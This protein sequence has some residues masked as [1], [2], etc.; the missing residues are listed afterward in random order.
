MVCAQAVEQDK[1]KAI[2]KIFIGSN[3]DL[4]DTKARQ[5]KNLNRFFAHFTMDN[6]CA[7]VDKVSK[8]YLEKE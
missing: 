2:R 6:P 3:Q 5:K 7:A 8:S 4:A 1:V